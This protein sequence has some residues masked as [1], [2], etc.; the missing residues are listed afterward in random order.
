[1]A[2]PDLEAFAAQSGITYSAVFVPQ[3]QSRHKGEKS[4]TLNWRVEL[5]R[6]GYCMATDYMQGIG[7]LP[8]YKP[9]R[10]VYEQER[11]QYAAE[12]G[13]YAASA[14]NSVFP[15]FRPVPPPALIDVL[16]ALSSDS[17]VIDYPG[18]EEW[19][20]DCGENT[21][22][23]KAEETYRACL[24]VALK[25]RRLL[26]GDSAMDKLRTACEDY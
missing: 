22:S 3:S 13:K 17:T 26:G 8:D 10:T 9:A 18:F 5:V 21:D 16:Y 24:D 11:Q 25:F 12:H 23:R 1:M 19:A 7:H 14:D 6:D 20:R 2:K 4:L 15:R